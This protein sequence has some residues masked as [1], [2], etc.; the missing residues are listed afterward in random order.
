MEA[1][2]HEAGHA[3]IASRSRF[4]RVV[5]AINLGR[6]GAGEI[7]ISLSKGKCAAAGKA[8]DQRDPE[9][10]TDLAIVLSAGLVAERIA[11][12]HDAT[13][14][15]NPECAQPDHELL[16]QQLMGAGLPTEFGHHEDEA[17]RLLESQWE[18][19]DYLAQFLFRH[20]VVQPENIEVFIEQYDTNASCPK[21]QTV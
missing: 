10:A 18:L 16:R 11:Q 2:Y 5:G 3:I 13:I 19:L 8:P 15:P 9:V 21:Q 14:E 17:Q 20:R 7:Y 4:H 6:Y 12:A 1:A